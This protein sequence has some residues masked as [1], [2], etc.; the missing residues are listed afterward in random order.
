MPSS[1]RTPVKR[2]KSSASSIN[3][4]VTSPSPQSNGN[5][6]RRPSVGSRR[7]STFSVQSPTTPRLIPSHDGTGSFSQLNGY[8]NVPDAEESNGLGNLA[9]ELA[10]A[11][12]EEAEDEVIHDVVGSPPS[13]RTSRQA[14]AFQTALKENKPILRERLSTREL[15]LSPSKQEYH[16]RNYQR[17]D[18]HYDGS[19]Y[20][21]DSDLEGVDGLTQSLTARMA[22][23]EGLARLGTQ[24][25]GSDADGVVQRVA[26]ALKNLGSQAGIENGTSRLITTHTALTSHLTNQTRSLQTLC[27]PLL[28][29]L[30][31]PPEAD[32]I[33]DM[34]PLLTELLFMLPTPARHP[35][36]AL[37]SL[38]ASTTELTSILTYL[39]DTLHMTRQTTSLATRRLRTIK[40]TVMDMRKEAEAMEESVR[41]IEKG[42][43]EARLEARDCARVCGDVVNGFEEVCSGWRERLVGGLGVEVGVA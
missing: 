28:S 36:T 2:R 32:T 11:F 20:G 29:P 17:H 25:N 42:E 5:S 31:A 1:P 10:E 33:D 16:S 43:W 7:S 39:S 34:L 9:D 14:Q 18:S 30:S 4:A 15:S 19:D 22:S 6:V 3:F 37:H 8:G 23:I 13:Q 27:H 26:D 12:D 38:H 35:L 41:W 40:E 21:D 24:S